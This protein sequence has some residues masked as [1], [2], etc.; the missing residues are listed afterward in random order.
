MSH[1]A[2]HSVRL[3]VAVAGWL[4]YAF[5]FSL[6]LLTF[7][8]LHVDAL[9][10]LYKATVPGVLILGSIAIAGFLAYDMRRFKH[11]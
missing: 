10:L 8:S 5:A 1:R 2:N 11:Q 7:E 6:A 3:G 9:I 4:C